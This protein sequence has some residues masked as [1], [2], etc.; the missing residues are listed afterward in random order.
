MD[1]NCQIQHYRFFRYVHGRV[2]GTNFFIAIS[3]IPGG[4]LSP[5]FY[6][7][8]KIIYFSL[9]VWYVSASLDVKQI[10]SDFK[11]FLRC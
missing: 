7:N 5:L 1:Q 4:Q 8:P 10:A 6:P 2:T 11:H 9:F 3:G